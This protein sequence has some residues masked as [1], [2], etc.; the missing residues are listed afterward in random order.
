MWKIHLQNK[1]KYQQKRFA[2]REKNITVLNSENYD[3]LGRKNIYFIVNWVEVIR[4]S[5]LICLGPG[6]SAWLTQ[7]GSFLKR[8]NLKIKIKKQN[9]CLNKFTWTASLEVSMFLRQKLSKQNIRMDPDTFSNFR[10]DPDTFQILG[11]IRIRMYKTKTYILFACL[12][13]FLRT[14]EQTIWKEQHYFWPQP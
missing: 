3:K 4:K 2:F 6:R 1:G 11:W 8:K 9:N 13:W 14:Q 12:F 10:V 5:E 7:S